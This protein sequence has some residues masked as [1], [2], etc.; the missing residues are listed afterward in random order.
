MKYGIFRLILLL[1]GFSSISFSQQKNNLSFTLNYSL[2]DFK[3]NGVND[4]ISESLIDNYSDKKIN[5]GQSFGGVLSYQPTRLLDIGIYGSYQ[6][7]NQ[8]SNPI[9]YKLKEYSLPVEECFGMQELRVASFSF[10][11]NSTIYISELFQ[12]KMKKDFLKRFHYGSELNIGIGFSK[13]S[14][15][16]Q[17][18]D[19][20]FETRNYIYYTGNS[21]QG[22][23]GLKVEYTFVKSTVFASLGLRGGYQYFKTNSLQDSFGNKWENDGNEIKLYLS[24]FYGGIYL[25]IAK[26]INRKFS[27]DKISF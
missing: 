4:L 1:L 14:N 10:G 7:A 8:K 3:M 16:I 20:V 18:P 5:S 2:N 24:G 11:I 13:F 19:H 25:K 22:K 15:D 21:L 12:D 9:Y 26:Q 17:P 6:F 27:R 23:L